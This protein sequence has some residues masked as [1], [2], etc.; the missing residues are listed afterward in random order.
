V[1]GDGNKNIKDKKS[2]SKNLTLSPS[3]AAKVSKPK[4]AGKAGIDGRIYPV[5]AI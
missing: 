3:V 4:R 1:P 5:S 2:K